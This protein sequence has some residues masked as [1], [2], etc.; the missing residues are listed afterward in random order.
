MKKLIMV[1]VILSK[2]TEDFFIILGLIL[3]I[4]ATFMLN[5]IAGMY[6]LGFISLFIGLLV[7]RKTPKEVIKN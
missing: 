6:I 1:L 3:I 4:I 2:F 5:K 7:A